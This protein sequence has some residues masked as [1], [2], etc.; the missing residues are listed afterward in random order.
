MKHW[1]WVLLTHITYIKSLQISNT[2]LGHFCY[3]ISL[4]MISL[5]L[6]I[7]FHSKNKQVH[8]NQ[9]MYFRKHVTKFW[10]CVKLSKY[11]KNYQD[12][13]TLVLIY[14][15][16][17]RVRNKP[18]AKLHQFKKEWR[19]EARNDSTNK[20]DFILT[21]QWLDVING[22]RVTSNNQTKQNNH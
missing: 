11:S 8:I 13:I 17:P 16:F 7:W 6:I 15:V 5:I 21:K 19:N 18:R 3:S 9:Q 14:N 22:G 2:N 1:F 4:R 10:K 20:K 12:K